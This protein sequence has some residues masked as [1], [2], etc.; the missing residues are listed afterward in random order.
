MDH[1]RLHGLSSK[2][3]RM[4]DCSLTDREGTNVTIAC[5]VT[6]DGLRVDY[7]VFVRSDVLPV[8]TMSMNLLGAASTRKADGV[9]TV[10]NSAVRF[11][12]TGAYGKRPKHID[13]VACCSGN[14]PSFPEVAEGNI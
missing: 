14:K 6:L 12:I 4:D 9:F 1:G 8:R 5:N 3:A 10:K 7:R 11:E 2:L 13:N